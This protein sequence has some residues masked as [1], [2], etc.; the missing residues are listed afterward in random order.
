MNPMVI[1]KGRH[2][3][4]KRNFILWICAIVALST[5]LCFG[6]PQAVSV[7]T[8]LTVRV[9]TQALEKAIARSASYMLTRTK[10]DGTFSYLENMNPEVKTAKSY[11][12]LRHAGAIYAM[13]QHH[14][15]HPTRDIRMA[16]ERAGRYL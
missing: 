11:N 15:Y 10:A 14:R 7:E 12:L 8:G 2:A 9:D 6:L 4:L 16:M 5:G 3:Q 13:G 1:A